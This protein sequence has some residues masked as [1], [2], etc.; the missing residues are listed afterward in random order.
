MENFPH[1]YDKGPKC[2]VHIQ[3]MLF[4]ERFP[5]SRNPLCN[6]FSH[7]YYVMWYVIDGPPTNILV[8]SQNISSNHPSLFN[9]QCLNLAIKLVMWLLTDGFILDHTEDLCDWLHLNFSSN[10]VIKVHSSPYTADISPY[11]GYE[12]FLWRCRDLITVRY[13]VLYKMSSPTSLV[14]VTP[15]YCK[16]YCMLSNRRWSSKSSDP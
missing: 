13:S 10:S 16:I 12:D 7:M 9:H 11:I 2:L 14:A 8:P 4:S 1:S 3:E 6:H 15:I 5:Q